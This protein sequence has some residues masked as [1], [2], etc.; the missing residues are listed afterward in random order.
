MTWGPYI[1]FAENPP[2][3]ESICPCPS[4]IVQTLAAGIFMNLLQPKIV[5]ARIG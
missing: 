3:Y 1:C 5:L 4:L 2:R